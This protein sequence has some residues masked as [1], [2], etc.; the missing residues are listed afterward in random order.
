M[1]YPGVPF[2]PPDVVVAS[3]I[4]ADDY[5]YW[6]LSKFGIPLLLLILAIFTTVICLTAWQSRSDIRTLRDGIPRDVERPADSTDREGG[7][8]LFKRALRLTIC[9]LGIFLALLA[10]LVFAIPLTPVNRS[11]V[12]YIVAILLILAGVLAVITFAVDINSERDTERCTTNEHYTRVCRSREDMGTGFTLWDAIMAIFFFISGILILLYSRSGDWTRAREKD[13]EA[14]GGIGVMPGLYPN[15]VSFVR[16]TITILALF[17][18]LAFSIINLVFIIY[19]HD[20]RDRVELRDRFNRIS[21]EKGIVTNPGWPQRNTKLRYATCSMIILTVL[22]NLIPLNSRVI[23][24]ILLFLYFCY[25]VLAFVCFAVDIDSIEDSKDLDCPDQF[26]CKHHPYA[27]TTAVEFVGG[28]FL[29][30]F[31]VVEYC[32]MGRKKKP[33]PPAVYA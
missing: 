7:I 12:N 2:S 32:I 9:V 13:L 29:I 5:R 10:L 20:L 18:L 23:A 19:V 15:G 11:R 1:L 30:I 24:Y 26:V 31:I 22:F 14:M 25:T 4:P 6:R 17:V 28:I 21:V 3:P 16:K 8:P 27:A 33:V